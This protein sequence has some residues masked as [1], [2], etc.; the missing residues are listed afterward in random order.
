MKLKD[1]PLLKPCYSPDFNPAYMIKMIRWELPDTLSYSYKK[2]NEGAWFIG[3][4]HEIKNSR[5]GAGWA[6]SILAMDTDRRWI[7]IPVIDTDEFEPIEPTDLVK[8]INH[9]TESG[10]NY[11]KELNN[12]IPK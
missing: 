5:F 12:H 1:I 8:Y 10:T 2:M 3:I 6:C 11:L 7:Q 9:L 4:M